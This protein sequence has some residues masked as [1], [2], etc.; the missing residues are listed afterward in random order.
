MEDANEGTKA[1]TELMGKIGNSAPQLEQLSKVMDWFLGIRA[2]KQTQKSG[3]S[4]GGGGRGIPTASLMTGQAAANIA[5][6]QL[7]KPYVYNTQGPDT[8]D[9]SGLVWYAY[10]NAGK[11]NIPRETYAMTD[12]AQYAMYSENPDMWRQM[13]RLPGAIL[14]KDKYLRETE[15]HMG[16]ATGLPGDKEVIESTTGGVQFSRLRPS[17]WPYVGWPMDEG[18]KVLAKQLPALFSKIERM[19]EQPMQYADNSTLIVQGT[20]MDETKLK[21]VLNDWEKEKQGRMRQE[22]NRY[23]R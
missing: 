17:K 6:E 10:T 20:G 9:C 19:A 15:G 5:M 22:L 18:G 7:G 23:R 1:F 16:M 14:M 13:V 3:S 21:R 12:F 4:G 2:E 8:F 11:L